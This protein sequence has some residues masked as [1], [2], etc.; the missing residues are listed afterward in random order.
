MLNLF[1]VFLKMILN[2]IMLLYLLQM[3]FHLR[4][5]FQLLQKLLLIDLYLFVGNLAYLILLYDQEIMEI[6]NS[7]EI[8]VF[9]LNMS[10]HFI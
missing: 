6:M 5:V 9:Y 2:I 1:F 7:Q 10:E 8:M 4:L 3:Q